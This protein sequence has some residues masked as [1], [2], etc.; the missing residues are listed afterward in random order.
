MAYQTIEA[1]LDNPSARKV[2][3]TAQE[4]FLTLG[5]S[6]V[7]MKDVAARSGISRSTLYRI[8]PSKEA[9]AFYVSLYIFQGQPLY[10]TGPLPEGDGLTRLAFAVRRSAQLLSLRRAQ[11]AYLTQFDIVFS[12]NYPDMEVSGYYAAYVRSM[13]RPFLQLIQEGIDDG[14]IRPLKDPRLAAVTLSNALLAMAQRVLPREEHFRREQ[15]YGGEML[16]ELAETLID[17]YA[18]R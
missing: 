3:D 10:Y 6:Q 16:T 1:L 17:A 9:L 11:V 7:E 14:S 2:L 18:N 15:G 12:G 8:F 5:Y 4:L 13:G